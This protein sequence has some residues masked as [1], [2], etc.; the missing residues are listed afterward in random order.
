[1]KDFLEHYLGTSKATPQF[2]LLG[3]VAGRKIALDLNETH[4]ISLFGVQ[5]GGK[6]YTLGTIIE[7]ATM[8]IPGI[9]RLPSPLAS[10]IF[11]YSNTQEYAPEFVSMAQ[12]NLEAQQL[13]T[14]KARY[15]AEGHALQDIL[16]LA[17]QDKVED[18]QREYPGLTV[19]PLLFSANE[20]QVSH[21]Q[22]LLNAVGNNS[23]YMRQFKSLMREHRKD[24][25]IGLLRE[26][27]ENS[28]MTPAAKE[29]ALARLD[30]AADYIHDDAQISSFLI[31]GRLIIVDLRD[32][33]IEKSEA[34]SLF[35]ILLQ[36]FADAKVDGQAFNKLV[37][38]D[39]AHKYIDD[40]ELIGNV[41]EIIREMRHKG[42][43]ILLASQDPSS[44]PVKMIEL[45]TQ[46][47]LHKFNSPAW[48]RHI[49]KANA[50]LASLTPNGMAE[51][52]PGEA[53]IWSSKASDGAFSSRAMKITG[54]PRVSRH[55]GDTKQAV[56]GE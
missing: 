50:A 37:V 55:G 35:V 13:A 16:L 14:L 5:G 22:F 24:L 20:L 38:F 33:F 36:L 11:H 56:S 6:S 39:E 51:L 1:M 31:P 28:T 30:L 17:P 27:V 45:S 43:S 3:E 54:R 7:M 44:V 52:R 2:G 10:V 49:Q 23:M 4:T 29:L 40:P 19:R 46:I 53:Y 18:R 26:A 8:S 12:A 9:N 48:L 41:V 42:T 25:K 15:G 34:L 21:W 32:E 47:I